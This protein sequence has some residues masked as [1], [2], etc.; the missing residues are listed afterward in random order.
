MFASNMSKHL[1]VIEPPR[2]TGKTKFKELWE[3]RELAW[4]MMLRDIK[5]RYKQ[6]VLGV[7]WA[8]IQ[9]VTM[10]LIFSFIF[11]RLAKIPSDGMPYP[12]FVFSGLLAW[13]FFSMAVS[14]SGNSMIGA[15]GMISKVYF[16][17]LIV[18]LAAIAVGGVDFCISLVLLIIIMIIYSVGISWQ[19]V[20]FPL[21]VFGLLLCAVGTGAW[22]SAI[23]VSYRDF[24]FVIPFMMQIW[25]YV[26]PVIYPLSFIPA[27]YRWLAYINPVFGWVDGIRAAILGN[28]I[29]WNGIAVSAVWTIGILY[30]GLRFF[31]R[32]ERRFADV[33]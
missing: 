4:M 28:V 30:L 23:T 17:R 33:I 14:S 6:T 24:R 27:D 26:T 16:P 3:Y 22:L 8:V 7:A 31:E 12:V 13:N 11:G 25:M 29:N 10:M 19:I 15:A 18:P 5:V 9:P 20:F 2:R 1:T 32:S 21:F